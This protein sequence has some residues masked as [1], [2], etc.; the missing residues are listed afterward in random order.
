MH[1]GFRLSGCNMLQFGFAL[2]DA[3]TKN[4]IQVS[5][6]ISQTLNKQKEAKHWW[7]QFETNVIEWVPHHWEERLDY[8][9]SVG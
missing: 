5:D 7:P 2:E 1:C 9:L 8:I 6:V 4:L 3:E